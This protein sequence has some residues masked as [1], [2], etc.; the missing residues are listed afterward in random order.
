MRKENSAAA[1]SRRVMGIWFIGF[2]GLSSWLAAQNK[3][4]KQNKREKLSGSRPP[5][6]QRETEPPIGGAELSEE[7]HPSRPA[8]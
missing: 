8:A 7:S 6:S 4:D 1:I 5:L 2:F 3:Q